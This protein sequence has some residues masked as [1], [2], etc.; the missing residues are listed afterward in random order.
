MS[1]KCYDIIK[2]MEEYAPLKMA[3]SWDNVGLMLG[4]ENADLKMV[5]TALDINDNV[6]D[7]AINIGADMIITHHPFIFKPIKNIKYSDAQGRRIIKL[8]K[9]NISVYSSHTNLDI[10]KGGTNDTICN[11]LGLNNVSGLIECEDKINYLGRVGFLK[12]D[13]TLTEFSEYV[14]LKLKLNV[15]SVSGNGN[16]IVKKVGVCTGKASGSVYMNAAKLL[17]CD[18]YLTGDVGYHDAQYALDIGLCVVD[19]T[20]YALE[21]CITNVLCSYMNEYANKN[22]LNFKCKASELN[23]ETFNYI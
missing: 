2:I 15:V 23:I 9:N 14:K 1:V 18:V 3:E 20:H 22:G 4:D 11:I 13:M 12:K 6:I 5:L 17:G 10:A 8:I 7:E 19:A 16:T 21:V